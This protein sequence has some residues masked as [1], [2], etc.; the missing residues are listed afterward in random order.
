MEPFDWKAFQEH[1]NLSDEEIEAWRADPVK[2]ESALRMH[3]SGVRRKWLIVE[4]VKSQRC[5]NGLKVGDRL[6]FEAIAKLD[7]VRSSRW[8]GHNMMF[9]PMVQDICHNLLIRGRDPSEG[10]FPNHF[11]CID[12]TSKYG[13]G[14]VENKIYVVDADDLDKIG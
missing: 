4:V 3:S 6:Y 1:M 11:S 12:T 9:L 8:C 7:P 5:G 14:Y 10:F 13:W 2:S